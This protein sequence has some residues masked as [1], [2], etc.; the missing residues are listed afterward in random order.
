MPDS[1]GR[2][3]DSERGSYSDGPCPQCGGPT[4]TQWI[5]ARKLSDV[6]NWWMPGRY[7]CA[8]PAR[9]FS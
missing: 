1:N 4:I 5:D 3:S 8:N 2:Y 7:R 6:Q 9:H